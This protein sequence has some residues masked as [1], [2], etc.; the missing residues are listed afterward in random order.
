MSRVLKACVVSLAAAAVFATIAGAAGDSLLVKAVKAG[1]TETVRKLLK[2]GADVNARSGDG[3]SPLLWAVH[4]SN[5][6]IARALI[7]AKAAVDT[8]ND[9][10]VTPLLDAS[11][12]GDATMVDLLLKS[13]A[14]PSLAHPEGET[15]LMAA[16]GMFAFIALVG[17][18]IDTGVAYRERRNI[19]NAADLSALA[20]T[21]VIAD[22]YLDGGRTGSEV[23][24]GVTNLFDKDPPFF[25]SGTSGTQAL[26]TIPAFYDVFGR[27]YYMGT[28]IKF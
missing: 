24:A 23:Y 3:S 8:A 27:S 1:D 21:K 16:A 22:H 15:P 9:Y 6:E 2:S 12:T 11:R 17:L 20:G 28:R 18:V 19:Q 7:A 14:N 4:S 25:A 10:G 5:V 13:G 26:D